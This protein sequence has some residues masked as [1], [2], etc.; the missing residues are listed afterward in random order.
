MLVGSGC[1]PAGRLD[2]GQAARHHGGQLRGSVPPTCP[3]PPPSVDTSKAMTLD[4][5]H[6]PTRRSWVSSAQ[7]PGTDFPIQNLPHGVFRRRGSQEPFRGGVAIGDQILDLGEALRRV[8]WDAEATAALSAASQP[9]LNGLMALGAPAWRTLRHALSTVLVEGSA[10]A[11]ALRPALLP[12]AEAEFDLPAQIGD[13][14]DFFSSWHHMVNAG[15]VFRPDAP[16]LPHFLHLPIA[17]HGRAS[18]VALSG[19]PVQRPWGITSTPGNP[20]RHAPVQCLDYELELG[21]WVGPGN[22]RGKPLSVAEAEQQIFGLCLLNDWSARD[23]QAFESLPLG[24]FLAK[25]FLTSISPWVVTWQALAPFRCELP[26][27]PFP[28]L[29]HLQPPGGLLPGL[30]LHLSAELQPAGASH[31]TRLSQSNL[32]HGSWSLAQMLAHHTEGGC[33]VRPG[34][35]MGTGT[36]SGPTEGE[37]GCLLELSQ[38]GRRPVPLAGGGSRTYLQDGDTVVLRAWAE[39]PGAARIGLGSCS[40]TV[41]AARPGPSA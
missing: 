8:T 14:T 19:T 16:P 12:Q 39:R 32:R 18:T 31:A 13:F 4:F 36:Q 17:Y 3:L 1:M 26:E 7:Q 22:A 10:L 6:D 15:R 35:L 23:V 24:P 20:P 30:D 29:A 11:P 27:R 9:R 34:D 38:G 28:P 21:F 37:Q 2:A 5:T 41:Q 33:Q 40:G 25:N